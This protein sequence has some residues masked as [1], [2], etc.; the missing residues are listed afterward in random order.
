AA[1]GLALAPAARP[2]ATTTTISRASRTR[3]IGARCTRA[4]RRRPAPPVDGDRHGASSPLAS[5]GR[6]R[7]PQ[8]DDAT[9]DGDPDV[10]REARTVPWHVEL[11]AQRDELRVDCDNAPAHRDPESGPS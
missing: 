11:R 5:L 3:V 8:V 9:L 2:P 7:E 1:C 6:G 10:C 4:R